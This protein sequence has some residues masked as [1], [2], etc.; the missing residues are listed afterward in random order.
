MHRYLGERKLNIYHQNCAM[1]GRVYCGKISLRAYIHKSIMYIDKFNCTVDNGKWELFCDRSKSFILRI[2]Q[3]QPLR[4]IESNLIY[5]AKLS[6]CLTRFTFRSFPY[7]KMII[8]TLSIIIIITVSFRNILRSPRHSDMSSYDQ[9]I[10]DSKLT[11]S[12]TWHNT[13]EL[14]ASRA[15]NRNRIFLHG[16]AR[17]FCYSNAPRGKMTAIRIYTRTRCTARPSSDGADR[18]VPRRAEITMTLWYA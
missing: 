18:W 1:R 6:I 11:V 14:S 2:M 3:W 10:S 15:G 7:I 13:H 8:I 17:A 4:V 16:I 5:T 12:N 9:L